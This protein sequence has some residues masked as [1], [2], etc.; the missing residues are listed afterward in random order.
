MSSE[1]ASAVPQ[2]GEFVGGAAAACSATFNAIADVIAA[3]TISLIQSSTGPCVVQ[4]NCVCS[5]NYEGAE[6]GAIPG[7]GIT[8]YA[9]SEV[10]EV[11]FSKS[12]TLHVHHF[13]T[14]SCCDKLTVGGISYVGTAGPAN[15]VSASSLSW[16]SDSSVQG[17]G[18]KICL[19]DPD[20]MAA[21]GGAP[22]P[23]PPIREYFLA[24]PSTWANA[25]A[26]C[27][28]Q[29]GDL[30]S[31]HS[32]EEDQIVIAWMQAEVH[33][34]YPWI[35]LSTQTCSNGCGGNWAAEYTWSDGTATDYSN[36]SFSQNDM[37]PTYGHYYKNMHVGGGRWGTWC[38][39]CV[40]EGICQRWPM[41]PPS[42]PLS[43]PASPG[44]FLMN[45]LAVGNA[46][47]GENGFD[48]LEKAASL[49][50]F[51]I[52]ASTYAIVTS[53]YDDGVQLI[54][55]SDPSSRVPCSRVDF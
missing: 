52:G 37:A 51:V 15:G 25:R 39:T 30:V 29:G 33:S 2:I 50:T 53:S 54:D 10:C 34:D 38:P 17:Q 43:P 41:L 9:N 48:K 5:S 47:D 23:S 4:G 3:S 55:V 24:G 32:A 12:A 49:A 21:G 19:S 20:F 26:Y 28:A 14:E 45:P 18:W 13:E 7:P 46:T 35:G 44:A 8:Q 27:V 16:A 6:C 31:I 22:S 42:P 11:T 36:P 40:S 1:C